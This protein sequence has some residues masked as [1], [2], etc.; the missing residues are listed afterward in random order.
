MIAPTDRQLTIVAF[1]CAFTDD[2]GY[3]PA[4]REVCAHFGWTST[5]S[6]A[7]HLRACIR[8]G[9]LARPGGWMVSRGVIA[10]ALGRSLVAAPPR[11]ARSTAPLHRRGEA[12]VRA[13]LLPARAT[14]LL[15]VREGRVMR[16]LFLARVL[17]TRPSTHCPVVAPMPTE[18]RLTDREPQQR[19]E[20]V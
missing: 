19:T 1:W 7:C 2:K 8:K 16:P 14:P 13:E 20:G 10:T 18:N 11:A 17:N 15:S 9:L 6:V 12:R 4:Q 5:N 3:P